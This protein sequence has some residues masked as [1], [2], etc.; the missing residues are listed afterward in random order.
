MGDAKRMMNKDRYAP[1]P[2]HLPRI[3]N[4]WNMYGLAGGAAG[5]TVADEQ[6]GTR[7]RVPPIP[8]LLKP[9]AS[10]ASFTA[11]GPTS[12]SQDDPRSTMTT[13]NASADGKKPTKSGQADEP[14]IG[15]YTFVPT[16]TLWPLPREFNGQLDTL[17]N[18]LLGRNA[19]LESSHSAWS[20]SKSGKER[21]R[22]ETTL[23]LGR[24]IEVYVGDMAGALETLDLRRLS[25]KPVRGGLGTVR[26]YDRRPFREFL[27]DDS[28]YVRY[29]APARLMLDVVVGSVTWPARYLW[30]GISALR[31]ESKR[32]DEWDDVERTLTGSMRTRW[33]VGALGLGKSGEYSSSVVIK[34]GRGSDS[35]ARRPTAL[36]PYIMASILPTRVLALILNRT[37]ILGTLPPLL[38]PARSF[39]NKSTA[40][41]PSS[42][43]SENTDS[44][45]AYETPNLSEETGT[46][47]SLDESFMSSGTTEGLDASWVGVGESN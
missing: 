4:V 47:P 25:R 44:A 37:P 17:E 11:L 43:A 27:R 33:N 35:R 7:S 23:V 18:L 36:W 34:L 46:M 9:P 31:R 5:S 3:R 1:L 6:G 30:S 28:V 14:S 42:T 19:V 29:L 15:L 24:H 2:K 45:P 38:P 21:K 39:T 40:D 13:T 32:R 12:I 10:Y 26:W 20:R 22:G 8:A 41:P 16:R